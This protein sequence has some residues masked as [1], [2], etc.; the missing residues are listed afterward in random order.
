MSDEED[1]SLKDGEETPT[2]AII[3]KSPRKKKARGET[4]TGAVKGKTKKQTTTAN[5]GKSALKKGAAKA[6]A[7]KPAGV[8]RKKKVNA[9]A[10]K[11]ETAALTKQEGPEATAAKQPVFGAAM[12]PPVTVLKKAS[13]KGD[14][15]AQK[16]LQAERRV[17]VKAPVTQLKQAG[18]TPFLIKV[19]N[20]DA[21]VT[22][23]DVHTIPNK[24]IVQGM[25]HLQIFYVAPD[26]MV[27]HMAE[28]VK[29]STMLDIPGARPGMIAHVQPVI[30][31]VLHQVMANGT[32]LRKRIILD[33]FVKMAQEVQL[34]LL[35][36]TGPPLLL[37]ETVGEGT[38]QVLVENE[39]TLDRPAI[40]VDEIH[41]EVKGITTE[42]IPHKVI[43]QGFVHKQIFYVDTENIERHQ[44][45]DVAFSG[46]VDI[47]GAVPGMNVQVNPAIETVIHRLEGETILRQKTVIGI[48]VK[49]TTPVQFRGVVGEGPLLRV[50]VIIGE[51][52]G[53]TL[54]R[55]LLALARPAEK[56]RDITAVL[57]GIKGHVIQDKVILQGTVHK[58]IYYIGLEDG[59]QYHQA[60]DVPFHI[61]A[62]IPGVAK[63]MD[64]V[65]NP[66]IE[67]VIFHLLSPSELEQKVL[68]AA[69]L[70]VVE[71]HQLN[72]ALGPGSLFCVEQVIGE[73]MRQILIAAEE[74]HPHGGWGYPVR[75]WQEAGA[76][77]Y[78]H[79]QAQVESIFSLETEADQIIKVEAEIGHLDYQYN[80]SGIIISG[81][82]NE[83]ITYVGPDSS[84][85]SFAAIVPFTMLVPTKTV[86]FIP[87]HEDIDAQPVPLSSMGTEEIL[88]QL[89]LLKTVTEVQIEQVLISISSDRRF[90][91]QIMILIAHGDIE[92]CVDSEFD[93][94]TAIDCEGVYWDYVLAEGMLVQPDGSHAWS[95]FKAITKVWGPGVGE[96][97]V[98]LR[99]A[100]RQLQL[101]GDG[102]QT[103]HVLEY[104]RYI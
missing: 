17:T 75:V 89:G 82:V 32:K 77:V 72:L 6:S 23:V 30:A 91:H 94:W 2:I 18:Q 45:E 59:I 35:P 42:V 57:T 50:P 56:I 62:D 90:L 1:R 86:T 93:V 51:G 20:I 16:E 44:A 80:K 11:H 24:V 87:I 64:L 101:V 47:P 66:V 36:G 70:T 78:Y 15:S 3:K 61:M 46:F 85:R 53:Q 68:V 81:D 29:F 73:N 95:Q 19:R 52:S 76:R 97:I 21:T 69:T 83:T 43:I 79:C 7:P 25:V 63:G 8:R 58:Q 92:Q 48:F 4:G 9:A 5:G 14:D 55:D 38:K 40:K 13:Y 60:E 74:Q 88:I 103:V 67:N 104:A 37:Q 10:A 65:A 71:Q 39:V 49:V 31:A 12:A 102:I 22:R 96:E 41:A 28:D 99:W 98:D 26:E 33:V 54:R 27:H 84:I 100:D 34:H